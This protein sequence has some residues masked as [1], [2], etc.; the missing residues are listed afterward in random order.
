MDFCR[1]QIERGALLCKF[2]LTGSPRINLIQTDSGFLRK[3][4]ITDTRAFK[5]AQHSHCFTLYFHFSF[6][7]FIYH[8][9]YFL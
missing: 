8:S 7:L 6:L 1:A 9:H 5:T 4:F 2:D 3:L